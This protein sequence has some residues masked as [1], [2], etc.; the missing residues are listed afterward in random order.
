MSSFCVDND[1]EI[2]I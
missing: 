1:E 2:W